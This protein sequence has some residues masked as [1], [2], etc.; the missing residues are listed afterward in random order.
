MEGKREVVGPFFFAGEEEVERSCAH[1]EARGGWRQG[2]VAAKELRG[3]WVEGRRGV[4][5][6]FPC[7][8]KGVKKGGANNSRRKRRFRRLRGA[9]RD[10][11]ACAGPYA[12][13]AAKAAMESEL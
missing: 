12:K 7:G 10:G 11:E 2:A 6:L 13:E 3:R 5:G 9:F 8:G 1:R 4:R